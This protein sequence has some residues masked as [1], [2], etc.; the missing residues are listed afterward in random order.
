[1]MTL[2]YLHPQQAEN[3]YIHHPSASGG[4]QQ[5]SIHPPP[6]APPHH[7][8][9]SADY[10]QQL[11]GVTAGGDHSAPVTG[12][13]STV[14]NTA[15]SQQPN[16]TPGWT[17]GGLAGAIAA[18]AGGA[19]P[20]TEWQYIHHAS[21]NS[22]TASCPPTSLYTGVSDDFAGG[23][24]QG[25]AYVSPGGIQTVAQ[26]LHRPM[27]TTY[28]WMKSSTYRFNPQTGILTNTNKKVK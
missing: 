17:N 24:S 5:Q 3:M 21:Q 8:F 14:S 27:M 16:S 4:F 1:M 7:Q 19:V 18:S 15:V 2:E 20:V 25:Q 6:P 22:N 10:W 11:H 12:A 26:A 9:A 23:H 13:S 28:D